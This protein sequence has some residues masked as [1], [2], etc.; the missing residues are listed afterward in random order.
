[1]KIHLQILYYTRL[2]LEDNLQ[3]LN[4]IHLYISAVISNSC[5]VNIAVEVRGFQPRL[6]PDRFAYKYILLRHIMHFV[7]LFTIARVNN[8]SIFNILNAN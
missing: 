4:I 5:T 6:C 7:L 3:Q 2:R 8:L 1:M